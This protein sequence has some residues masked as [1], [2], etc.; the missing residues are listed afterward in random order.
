[1]V[2]V[3]WSPPWTGVRHRQLAV[4]PIGAR[5]HRQDRGTSQLPDQ[6]DR[7]TPRREQHSEDHPSSSAGQPPATDPPAVV[8]V[9]QRKNSISNMINIAERQPRPRAISSPADGV[10]ACPQADRP[11][12]RSAGTAW[13]P[14]SRPRDPAPAALV[15]MATPTSSSSP[16]LPLPPTGSTT[17]MITIYGWSTRTIRS[18]SETF[19]PPDWERLK[20]CLICSKVCSTLACSAGS[21]TSQ[22]FCG[23]RRIRA[24]L[25]P[26]RL[27]V[28]RKLAADAHAVETSREIDSPDA[29]ILPFE[30]SNV[31]VRDQFMIDLRDGVPP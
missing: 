31:L 17:H 22:S 12:E 30:H 13:P 28:P 25:A 3:L 20:A 7:A 10:D 19:V 15:T 2:G 18:A 21:L 11:T 16:R 14:P 1:M 24:P 29:R 4:I 6:L 5:E 9:W 23:V 8:E 26:P 27:S